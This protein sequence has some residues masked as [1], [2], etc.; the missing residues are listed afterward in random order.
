MFA[1]V[2]DPVD[3]G[4]VTS[5][6][7]PGGN[8]TDFTHFELAFGGKWFEALKEIAPRMHRVVSFHPPIIPHC[9]DSRE[10]SRQRRRRSALRLLQPALATRASWNTSSTTSR[11]GRTEADP[12]AKLG[13]AAIPR[14]DYRARGPPSSAGDLLFP[15]FPRTWRSL[16]LWDRHERFIPARG[17]IR[18]SHQGRETGRSSSAG[19]DQVRARAHSVGF[20]SG[21]FS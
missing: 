10:R 18:G 13:R 20:E 2:P 11:P 4:I 5:I 21:G 14:P 17:I 15:L 6:A 7:R 1:Q 16:F 3:H 12:T 8:I 19:A 9:S